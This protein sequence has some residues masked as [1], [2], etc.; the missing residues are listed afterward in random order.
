MTDD[1]NRIARENIS[2]IRVV[3]AYNAEDYQ[4]EKFD[5]ANGRLINTQLF[6]QRLFAAMMPTMSLAMNGLS[7]AVYWIGAS[8][9]GKIPA[10]DVAGRMTLFSD[11]VVFGTYAT[12]IIMSLCR[13]RR[14]RQDV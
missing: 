2:G 7:L 11:I 3:H 9:I 5:D 14:F 8:L 1:I 13:R 4:N 6:N 12:Y 10:S